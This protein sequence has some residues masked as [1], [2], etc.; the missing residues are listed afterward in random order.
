[1]IGPS[2][3]IFLPFPNEGPTITFGSTSRVVFGDE[4]WKHN[5]AIHKVGIYRRPN[6]SYSRTIWNANDLSPRILVV[7]GLTGTNLAPFN[8]AK[9]PK[10]RVVDIYL[11][12]KLLS[13]FSINLLCIIIYYMWDTVS[14]NRKNHVFSFLLQLIDI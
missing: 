3:L 4:A 13:S 7:S 9:A 6:T 8:L 1:M 11:M 5:E 10:L 14:T 12:D 2:S